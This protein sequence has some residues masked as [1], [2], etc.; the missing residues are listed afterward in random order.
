M[1]QRRGRRVL[2]E[3]PTASMADI[4]FLLIIFFLVSTTMNQDKGLSLH[5]PATG[6]GKEVQKKNICNIWISK[7][8]RL[9]FFEDE[10]LTEIEFAA[11]RGEVERRLMV[12]DKLIVSLKSER[13][14]TYRTFVDVLDELKLA[15]ATRISIASP[16]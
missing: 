2:P 7:D 5:L 14:A 15:G 12:N 13:E 16:E 3:I 11:L 1:I 6:E 10:N 4:A 8:D 9:A